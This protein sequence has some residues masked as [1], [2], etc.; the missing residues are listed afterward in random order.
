[1][2]KIELDFTPKD[3][4]ADPGEIKDS[5][6][7]LKGLN[8]R[9]LGQSKDLSGQFNS[10]SMEFSE[11]VAW[12][13]TDESK[14]NSNKWINASESVMFCAFVTEF[15]HGCV[16]DFKKK[17]KQIVE[18]WEDAK[19]AAEKAVPDDYEDVPIT[20]SNH[21]S[22]APGNDSATKKAVEAYYG[23]VRKRG[24]LKK[25][26]STNWSNLQEGK[27]EVESQLKGGP[28]VENIKKLMDAGYVDMAFFNLR[29]T[30]F[31][32]NKIDTKN[33][34]KWPDKLSKYWSGEKEL[35]SEYYS[36]MML[37]N[38][39]GYES[40][41][42]QALRD[43]SN[44]PQLDKKY[45]DYLKKFYSGTENG[46]G[47]SGNTLDLAN[48]IDGSDLERSEK[49]AALGAI[50]G[51]LLTLS[52]E[53]IGG[54]F[55]ELPESIRKASSGS[56]VWNIKSPEDGY[57]T[58]NW[59][60]DYKKLS[61]LLGNA[62]ENL[63]GGKD[64]SAGISI[65]IGQHL[66]SDSKDW[67]DEDAAGHL[68]E[69]AARNK[70]AN[71]GI[72]TDDYTHPY[73]ENADLDDKEL[74]KL[75]SLNS[76]AVEGLLKYEW[77]DKDE[78]G[79]ESWMKDGK[80]V[81]GLI[82]WL[83][84]DALEDNPEVRRRAG[85]ASEG[86]ISMIT[87]DEMF[88]SLTD[89]GIK[90]SGDDN[91]TFSRVNPEICEKLANIFYSHIDDFGIESDSPR[92]NKFVISD[93]PNK[94]E[95]TVDSRSRARF[96]QYLVANEETAENLI[97]A[98]EAKQDSTFNEYMKNGENPT[99]NAGNSGRLK[100]LLDASIINESLERFD[101][102]KK[103]YEAEIKLKKKAMDKVIDL[104]QADRI[105]GWQYYGNDLK[106]SLTDVVAKG[107]TEKYEPIHGNLKETPEILK[108]SKNG[109]KLD[110]QLKAL[111]YLES[112]GEIEMEDIS[113]DLK[114]GDKLLSSGDF[115][116]GEF[117]RRRTSAEDDLQSIS[118][119][120]PARDPDSDEFHYASIK[121]IPIGERDYYKFGSDFV[122]KY[123]GEHWDGY[124]YYLNKYRSNDVNDY[125]TFEKGEDINAL[126]YYDPSSDDD[127]EEKKDED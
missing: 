123:S 58:A 77:P 12:N 39:I 19:K 87:T 22:H 9:M 68:V 62:P 46:W 88:K 18:D 110:F 64:F 5:H 30:D 60:E 37:L 69:V 63:Q 82:D 73:I 72:L 6:E 116:Q 118:A 14:Y 120:R 52:D 26:D 103:A 126:P 127:K 44:P 115:D 70:D 61:K 84:D 25:E 29:G 51:G 4:D 36:M 93:D 24:E 122:D 23:L 113:S 27:D 76:D 20:E 94:D 15:W 90:T 42:V 124:E 117:S 21:P 105:P 106:K 41:R 81:T 99:D 107:M 121:D 114:K 91:A 101:D 45:R 40:S 97:Q 75:K 79:N 98:V 109:S 55:E 100:G 35:D 50:G 33:V 8:K 112:H 10:T 11:A 43:S 53:K 59:I 13:I 47:A 67:I 2:A 34:E 111:D 54:G 56:F 96:M 102:D 74:K 38:I 17:R 1:M 16:N 71:H 119:K 31:Y 66:K 95:L 78:N 3:T 28:N 65:S 108:Y 86:L 57:D 7:D 83:A 89:T 32:L 48:L 104:S 49:D 85:E 80:P 125:E 92:D